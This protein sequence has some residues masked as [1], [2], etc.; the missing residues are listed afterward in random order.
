MRSPAM[1]HG[2][3]LARLAHT[4][5]GIGTIHPSAEV[6]ARPAVRDQHLAA[7]RRSTP[8]TVNECRTQRRWRA[9]FGPPSD[10]Y[11][12]PLRSH[13]RSPEGDANTVAVHE[14]DAAQEATVYPAVACRGPRLAAWS[15]R[16][17]GLAGLRCRAHPRP[18]RASSRPPVSGTGVAG[19]QD[20]GVEVLSSR[21]LVRPSGLGRSN[22]QDLW[23]K[24]F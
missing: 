5:E 9:R 14:L 4:F 17:A 1:E 6:C 20:G 13:Q 18:D 3:R 10:S 24:I 21:I 15:S 23:I 8:P 22:S 12:P 16:P 2:S 7:K 11:D 19:C